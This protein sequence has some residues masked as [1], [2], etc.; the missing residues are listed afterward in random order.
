[1]TELLYFN[2]KKNTSNTDHIIFKLL[3]K[4]KKENWKVDEAERILDPMQLLYY[5]GYILAYGVLHLLPIKHQENVMN[6]VDAGIMD[7]I[8][9]YYTPDLTDSYV[10][11][12]RFFYKKKEFNLP[13]GYI[14]RMRYVDE[15]KNI[16]VDCVGPQGKTKVF[17]FVAGNK[18][19]GHRWEVWRDVNAK[20]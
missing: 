12:D 4:N 15:N 14:P 1:M 10:T 2:P 17:R 5:Y 20:K 16:L 11:K 9:A 7:D 18:K 13:E 8:I 19:K 3:P 6:L